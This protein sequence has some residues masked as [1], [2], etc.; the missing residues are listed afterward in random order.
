MRGR[1]WAVSGV[2]LLVALLGLSAF[3]QENVLK[4]GNRGPVENFDP[5]E[6]LYMMNGQVTLQAYEP[7]LTYDL[8]TYTPIPNL[9][10]KWEYSDDLTTVSYTHLTLPTN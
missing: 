5:A 4:L 1:W 7:L 6:V 10:R 8:D 9:A 3:A 2:V